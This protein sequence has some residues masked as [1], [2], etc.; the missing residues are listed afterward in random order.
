MGEGD[1]DVEV[2]CLRKRYFGQGGYWTS[3]RHDVNLY[4]VQECMKM[5]DDRSS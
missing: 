3:R 5:A 4:R 1:F 2:G